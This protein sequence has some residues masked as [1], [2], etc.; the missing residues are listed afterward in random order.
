MQRKSP[1]FL[2]LANDILYIPDNRG[3]RISATAL[4]KVLGFGGAISSALIYT[5]V[6]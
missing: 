4:E 1:D 5:G 2:L 6:R 3:G